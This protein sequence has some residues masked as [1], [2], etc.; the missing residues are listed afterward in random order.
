MEDDLRMA[1]EVQ[2]A[3]LPPSQ[4]PF[5]HDT[6]VLRVLHQ[7]LPAGGVSGDFFDVIHLPGGAT[8]LLVCDVMGHGVRSAL[9]T[10]WSGRCLRSCGRSVVSRE[11][12]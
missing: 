2:L 12:C 4:R 7:F 1:R 3:M 6:K 10:A 9:I 11:S 5:T 8:G